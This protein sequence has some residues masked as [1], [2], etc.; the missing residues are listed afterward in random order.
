MD[1]FLTNIIFEDENCE[2]L[3]SKI[4]LLTKLFIEMTKMSTIMTKLLTT[5]TR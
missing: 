4:F 2:F 1:F 3:I 5:I